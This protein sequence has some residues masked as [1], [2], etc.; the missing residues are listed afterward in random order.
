M[1]FLWHEDPTPKRAALLGGALGFMLLSK[2]S[3]LLF[4]PIVA[5]VYF[6]IVLA[7][8]IEGGIAT[9]RRDHLKTLPVLLLVASLSIWAGYRFSFGP[10]P[11]GFALPAPEF[12]SGIVHAANRNRTP[13]YLLGQVNANGWWYFYYVALLVKTPPLLIPLS[14]IGAFFSLRKRSL[15]AALAVAV[16][17]ALPAAGIFNHVDVGIRHILPVYY[18]MSMLGALLMTFLVFTKRTMAQLQKVGIVVILYAFSGIR[19]HPDYLSYFNF[20]GRSHPERI[21]AGSDLDWGQDMKR[22]NVRLR[23]LRAES[24]SLKPLTPDLLKAE[25]GFPPILPV[26]PMTPSP[27]WNAVSLSVLKDTRLGL[28][29]KQPDAKL[30]PDRFEPKERIG[31]GML[32]YYFPPDAKQ[33]QVPGKSARTAS[34]N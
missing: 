15:G 16:I 34:N 21:M 11:W 23:Q 29:D 8:N 10:G 2:F 5:L 24:V 7:L 19:A 12:F 3:A 1:L 9:L 33:A 6:L 18:P 4:F 17:A 27:G 26:D 13:A 31:R 22:L 14:A 28:Y 32:L 25:P 30:W 20:L